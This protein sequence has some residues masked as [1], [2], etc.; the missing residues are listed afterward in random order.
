MCWALGVALPDFGMMSS[1]RAAYYI[2][3]TLLGLQLKMI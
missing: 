3:V 1:E 2:L